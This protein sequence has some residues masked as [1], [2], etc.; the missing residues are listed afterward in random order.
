MKENKL[1]PK[2]KQE[3]KDKRKKLIFKYLHGLCYVLSVLFIIICIV[4]GVNSCSKGGST[5]KQQ[6]K[7]QLH[8]GNKKEAISDYNSLITYSD[9]T[10][11]VQNDANL[12][13]SKIREY[14]TNLATLGPAKEPLFNF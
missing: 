11:V 5:N 1:T 7:T 3:L 6:D 10:Y 9:G 8:Y 4:C 12:T 2:Q 13:A 14:R